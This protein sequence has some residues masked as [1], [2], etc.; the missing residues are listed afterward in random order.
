MF[1]KGWDLTGL[2]EVWEGVSE[3]LLPVPESTA[4]S[5]SSDETFYNTHTKKKYIYIYICIIIIIYD[6]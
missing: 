3:P 1:H 5:D 4:N 6:L 2:L